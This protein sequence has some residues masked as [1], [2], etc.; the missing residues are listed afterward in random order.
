MNVQTLLQE[1]EVKYTNGYSQS[2]IV[3]FVYENANN[4]TQAEKILNIIL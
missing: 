1:A 3:D 2:R 4:E